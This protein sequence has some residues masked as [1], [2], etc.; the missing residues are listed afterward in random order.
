MSPC[1]HMY[2]CKYEFI[3]VDVSVPSD[4]IVSPSFHVQWG[5]TPLLRAAQNDH[6]GVARFLL[7][8]GSS[9]QEQDHVG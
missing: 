9:A 7:A 3:L 5:R 8:R 2:V 6:G 4:S 1:L